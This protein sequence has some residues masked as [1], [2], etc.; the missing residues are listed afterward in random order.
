MHSVRKGSVLCRTC[1]WN[2]ELGSQLSRN[3]PSL[4]ELLC[5]PFSPTQNST[6]ERARI[7][8]I[9]QA[10]TGPS[11]CLRSGVV[12]QN[13]G[14]PWKWQRLHSGTIVDEET[15]ILIMACSRQSVG[16]LSTAE[17]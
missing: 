4:W 13:I 2:R 14:R 8:S 16:L 3:G 11:G 7:I 6:P 12:V 17:I 10:I 1:F 9:A 15:E 5:G